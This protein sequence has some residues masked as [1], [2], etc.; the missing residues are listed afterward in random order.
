[1]YDCISA[2]KGFHEY[3][4]VERG[5]ATTS[6]LHTEWTGTMAVQGD[7]WVLCKQLSQP[8]FYFFFFF[9]SFCLNLVAKAGHRTERCHC[10][11]I[12]KTAGTRIPNSKTC[13]CVHQT[14]VIIICIASFWEEYKSQLQQMTSGSLLILLNHS[15]IIMKSNGSKH[16]VYVCILVLPSM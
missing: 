16:R 8:Y 14:T 12:S 1:M 7:S 6:R 9:I 5:L 2:E 15:D 13:P 4:E 3:D 11:Q 10:P